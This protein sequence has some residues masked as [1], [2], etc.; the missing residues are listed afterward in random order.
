M[1]GMILVRDVMSR[2]VKTVRVDDTAHDAVV[3]MNKFG[4]GSV[5]VMNGSRPVGII[6]STNILVH[7]VEPRRDPTFARAKEIMSAPLTTIESDAPL[8]EAAHLM[9]QRNIKKLPVMEKDKLAGVI[10]TTDLVKAAP[11]Q[12]QILQE[13]LRI[14]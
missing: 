12:I 10:S 14:S 9:A 1:S 13:L 8:E 11:T 5:I 7:V 4:V 3:K 6:T 2:N